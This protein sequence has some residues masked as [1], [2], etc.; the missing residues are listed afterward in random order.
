[1]TLPFDTSQN[2]S[3][4]K[5]PGCEGMQLAIDSTSLG[6][7]KECPRK[8]YYSVIRGFQRKDNVHLLFGL[9]YHGALER[10]DHAKAAGQ[11]H[12]DSV[13]AAVKY[14][15]K[16]TWNSKLKRPWISGD[17]NKNRLSLL[18]T[19]V[20][21]LDRFEKDPCETIILANGKPAVELSFT[22][23]SGL[24]TSWGEQISFCGHLDKLVNLGGEPHPLD[25]KTTK[26]TIGP[27][28]FKQ[29]TPN[30]QFSLYVL[31]T[32]VVWQQPAKSIICDGV[33]IA[34][35][36][37]RFERQPIPRSAEQLKEWHL[38]A[39]IWIQDME[40][41]ARAGY[42]RQND[43][44]CDKYGGCPF[45]EICSK[46]GESSRELWIKQMFAQRTWDPL[47]ARGDI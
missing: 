3:F 18:R 45:R 2:S 14:V 32:N 44:S 42:W 15:M 30:N 28:F 46:S 13:L 25:R 37:S 9:W 34:V 43:Q 7:Y 36:F 27:N 41:S 12:D 6:A 5:H 29:F 21:Y 11:N 24:D 22:F 35:N 38:D 40:Q 26:H 4:S 23:Y 47:Q 16:E 19:V 8:Y 1:M 20:D 39:L 10:Y 17:T 33:Q 31:A